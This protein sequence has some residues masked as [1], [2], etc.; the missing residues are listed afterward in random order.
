[1]KGP[2]EI[3]RREYDEPNKPDGTPKDN[4]SLGTFELVEMIKEGTY[5]GICVS[6]EVTTGKHYLIAETE[7]T[8][9]GGGSI[10]NMKEIHPRSEEH[11][12]YIIHMHKQLSAAFNP[13]ES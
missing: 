9:I 12:A 5:D 7:T 13:K 3:F 4:E 11:L 6:K 2:V 10:F 1:M 8:G